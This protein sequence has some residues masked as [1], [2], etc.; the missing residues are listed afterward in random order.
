MCAYYIKWKRFFLLG[1]KEEIRHNVCIDGIFVIS[2][3]LYYTYDHEISKRYS[4]S[5][6]HLKNWVSS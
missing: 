4:W 5:L 6:K 3:Y 2:V 1:E